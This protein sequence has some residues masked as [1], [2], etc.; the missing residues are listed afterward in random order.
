MTQR[1]RVARILGDP[2]TDRG[3]A[4]GLASRAIFAAGIAGES[5]AGHASARTG[6][7]T[8]ERVAGPTLRI[9]LAR[10]ARVGIGAI[11]FD[12]VFQ[13]AEAGV[14]EPAVVD[15]R[16]VAVEARR[17]S[18]VD[19]VDEW[20]CGSLVLGA[21]IGRAG[22]RIVG[23]RAHPIHGDHRGESRYSSTRV[24][25]ESD[26]LRSSVVI[27]TWA[28]TESALHDCTSRNRSRRFRASKKS[29]PSFI[30]RS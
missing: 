18:R 6:P 30:E 12:V 21:G 22:R 4:A 15:R 8:A 7:T 5:E 23:A 3:P 29:A 13:I 1:R 2:A 9:R 28:M 24:S 26:T 11:R 10:A 25:P 16:V 19:V 14:A 27:A 20:R 17:L